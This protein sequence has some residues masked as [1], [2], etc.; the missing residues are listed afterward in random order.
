MQSRP[1]PAFEAEVFVGQY[2]AL[3]GPGGVPGV[4]PE[5]DETTSVFWLNSRVR[6]LRLDKSRLLRTLRTEQAALR[7]ELAAREDELAT[8]R[9]A[10][11]R[12]QAEN[13]RLLAKLEE[14]AAYARQVH[15]LLEDVYASRSWRLAHGLRQIKSALLGRKT[16]TQKSAAATN[17]ATE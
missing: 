12:E 14:S 5:G 17:S 1:R 13:G 8:V 6:A 3:H 11:G 15:R 2:N 9:A 4:S 10:L 16:P 7:G